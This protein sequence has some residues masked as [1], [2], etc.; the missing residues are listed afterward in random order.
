MAANRA[1]PEAVRSRSHI[2]SCSARSRAGA[3]IES[4]TRAPHKAASPQ[5]VR[6][7][8]KA[9]GRSNEDPLNL[10]SKLSQTHQSEHRCG[11]TPGCL[12]AFLGLPVPDRED[13]KPVEI[14]R[15][16]TV[17]EIDAAK[18]QSLRE[19]FCIALAID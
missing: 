5:P 19:Q 11:S 1:T 17:G 16:I 2:E 18:L 3:L 15:A 12:E 4:T 9:R 10:D 7:S 13:K 8:G 14:L 6:V